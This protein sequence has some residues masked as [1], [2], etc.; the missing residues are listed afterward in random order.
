LLL[1]AKWRNCQCVTAPP[2]NHF[3]CVL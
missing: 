2:Y 3:N 1:V